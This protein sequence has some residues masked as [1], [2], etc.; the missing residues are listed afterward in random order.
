MRLFLKKDL[1]FDLILITKQP[2]KAFYA[3]IYY[4]GCFVLSKNKVGMRL[5]LKKDLML[6]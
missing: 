4:G 5:F 3:T 2:R 1:I 6:T